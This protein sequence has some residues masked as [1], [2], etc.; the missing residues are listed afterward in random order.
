MRL[1][2]HIVVDIIPGI[3]P[4]PTARGAYKAAWRTGRLPNG[5]EVVNSLFYAVLIEKG[6]RAENVKVGRKLIDALT[7][8]V[9]LK[10]IGGKVVQSR[11]GAG[12]KFLAGGQTRS[13]KVAATDS[14]ARSIAWAVAK[15]MQKHGIFNHGKGWNVLGKALKMAPQY[16][17]EE[18]QREL[19]REWGGG[20]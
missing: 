1:Q 3:S 4:E 5:A 2:Q 18:V 6:V 14:E 17:R 20:Q 13:V 7:E 8:W 19:R 16:I 9:K 15:S 12:G 10:G 11:R